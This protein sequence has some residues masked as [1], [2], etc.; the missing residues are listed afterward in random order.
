METKTR[1]RT[2]AFGEPYRFVPPD[3]YGAAL[4]T[5][6]AKEISVP[7]SSLKGLMKALAEFIDKT[8]SDSGRDLMALESRDVHWFDGNAKALDWANQ[9]LARAASA[10]EQLVAQRRENLRRIAKAERRIN[11]TQALTSR[12]LGRLVEGARRT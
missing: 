3:V 2:E 8:S 1:D 11:R 5:Y 7:G 4:T 10:A 6:L 9:A 12:M